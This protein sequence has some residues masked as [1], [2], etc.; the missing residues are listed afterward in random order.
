MDKLIR[1]IL[2][3]LF[4]CQGLANEAI[5]YRTY[6]NEALEHRKQF[7]TTELLNHYYIISTP[8]EYNVLNFVI[9][10]TS[11]QIKL[12][13]NILPILSSNKES[14]TI[15][16][17]MDLR[18]HLWTPINWVKV[19]KSYPYTV[20][21][22]PLVI[23]GDW[24]IDQLTD[25][26]V[27]DGYYLLLYGKRPTKKE[28]L[29]AW[30]VDTSK[31]SFTFGYIEGESRVSVQKKRLIESYPVSRGSAFSTKDSLLKDNSEDPLETLTNVNFKHDGEEWIIGTPKFIS[32]TGEWGTLHYYNL[33]NGQN[34]LVDKADTDLVEDFSRFKNL[35]AIRTPGSCINCHG[36]I[37]YNIPTTNEYRDYILSGAK[38]YT[39]SKEL[40]D[41]I[42]IFYGSNLGKEIK[43]GNE[44]YAVAI[45]YLFQKPPEEANKQFKLIISKYQETLG[46][47]EAA[48][49]L[50]TSSEDLQDAI[51]LTVQVT[52]N[53]AKLAHKKRITRKQFENNWK[54][55]YVYRK[56]YEENLA[57]GSK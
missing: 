11:R 17:H 22:L 18:S 40:A 43:R 38:V 4:C 57:N 16:C 30:G 37:G 42:D 15:L 12:D 45:E 3:I 28:F 19:L 34:E 35:A 29:A 10:S 20:G 21:N 8:E 23:R 2:W 26:T 39:Q 6:A 7:P 56:A 1:I 5:P 41:F 51:G 32:G 48:R 52:A 27:N 49:E 44:D 36:A 55:L 54:Q 47:D 9:A 24:L 14:N 33:F 53:I 13:R 25:T 46:L 31:R 50:Y